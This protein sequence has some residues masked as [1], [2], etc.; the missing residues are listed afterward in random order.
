MVIVAKSSN[1]LVSRIFKQPKQKAQ[2]SELKEA[3]VS[4]VVE[5]MLTAQSSDNINRCGFIITSDPFYM[6]IVIILDIVIDP[7]IQ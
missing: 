2:G 5:F 6:N 4:R 1:C 7:L 3:K